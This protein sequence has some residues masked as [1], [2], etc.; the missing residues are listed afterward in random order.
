MLEYSYKFRDSTLF[1]Y[2]NTLLKKELY[3]RFKKIKIILKYIFYLTTTLFGKALNII[4]ST[5][6]LLFL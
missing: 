3:V 1:I 2:S 4:G 5:S 6:S